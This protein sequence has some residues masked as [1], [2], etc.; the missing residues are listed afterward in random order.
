MP[1]RWS[2]RARWAVPLAVLVVLA[3]AVAWI[4]GPLAGGGQP[5]LA[6]QLR[7]GVRIEEIMSGLQ[8]LEQIADDHNG[9]RAAGTSGYMASASYVAQE[10]HAAG[11]VVELDTFSVPLFS[12]VG[13]GHVATAGQRFVS[14]VDFRPMIFSAS[15][16]LTAPLVA[17]SYEVGV[18]AGDRVP[19][20]GCSAADFADVPPRVI[21]LV[22]NGP[23][24][25]RDVVD[26]ATAAGAAAL[27]IAS[28][29]W[30]PGSVRRPTL[31]TPDV[32]IPVLGATRQMGDALHR[33]AQADQPVTVSVRTA[34]VE[35]PAA[36]V[37]AQTPGGDPER[38]VMLGAHLDS[39]IDG[40]GINDNGSGAMSVLEIARQLAAHPPA[41]TVR[42]AFWA[43]EEIG[44]YG[45][46][47]YVTGLSFPERRAIDVYLNFDMLASPNGGRFVYAIPDAPTGSAS[48]TDAFTAYLEDAGLGFA[49]EDLGG[50]SDHA[51]FQRG[52]VPVGGLF[53]GASETM[54]AEASQRFG[55][56]TVGEPFDPCFHLECDRLD[57]VDPGLL[58]ELARAAAYV[59][60]IFASG[61]A[62]ARD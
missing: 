12:E 23:C 15:G 30:E 28:T 62:S 26:N 39:V 7:D 58:L 3:G 4:A 57:N 50:A 36:N 49:L 40:P 53:S 42:V 48:V 24:G 11:M 33:A 29:S 27:I 5:R 9:M 37:I 20:A 44:L 1:S 34:I 14:D 8:V 10:L 19:G 35:R 13:T 51:A 21:I 18:D 47:R 2:R 25:S 56:G 60:G 6:D 43:A 46:V 54:D 16:D 52:G 61:E 55:R 59:T 32:Q 45:S 38:V 41:S 17:V 22:Q 31:R